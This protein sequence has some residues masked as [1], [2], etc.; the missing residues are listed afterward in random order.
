MVKQ[1]GI[2]MNMLRAID[3]FA[4]STDRAAL[5]MDRSTAQQSIDRAARSMDDQAALL[6]PIAQREA[7]TLSTRLVGWGL[8]A[9]LTQ[10]RSNHDVR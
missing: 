7:M 10:F 3:G 4:R 9:L 6:P 2:F 1:Q 8:T 5:T